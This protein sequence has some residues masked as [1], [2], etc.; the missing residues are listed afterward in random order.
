M[1]CSTVET[2]DTEVILIPNRNVKNII[3]AQTY[4][5]VICNNAAASAN[6]PVF[7]R[8]DVGDIPVLCKAGN[9]MYANQLNTRVRYP[10]IY[11]NMNEN[12]VEGQFVVLSC[13]NP[14]ATVA[15]PESI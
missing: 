13:V 1:Y 12:Y 7:I 10:I 4:G 8:T 6:L 9:T 5:L 14:R 15:A 3:N 2:T 11:G